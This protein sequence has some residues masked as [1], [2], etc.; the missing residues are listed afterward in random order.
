MI[1]LYPIEKF[2]IKTNLNRTEIVE[3]LEFEVIKRQ[4]PLLRRYN[5]KYPDK[6]FEGIVYS[7]GFK[8][9]KALVYGEV[10]GWQPQINGEIKNNLIEIELKLP[11]LGSLII[12]FFLVLGVTGLS[13]LI[14]NIINGNKLELFISIWPLIP[15]YVFVASRIA[16]KKARKKTKIILK[17]MFSSNGDE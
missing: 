12:L 5:T 15:F 13:Y 9:S 7:N 14:Y 3:I 1:N 4:F 17:R 2:S 11:T 16:Y 8:I 10:S 6:I